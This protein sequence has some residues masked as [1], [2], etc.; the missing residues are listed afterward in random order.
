MG[1][2][3]VA[4]A[5]AAAVIGGCAGG[6]PRQNADGDTIPVRYSS[7]LFYCADSP[8]RKPGF[9]Y[10]TADECGSMRAKLVSLQMELLECRPANAVACFFATDA[11]SG[12]VEKHCHPTV[13]NCITS[14][15]ALSD[16]RDWVDE[17]ECAVFRVKQ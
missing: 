10:D 11:L 8:N 9:C 6:Q 15:M 13:E 4:R 7:H 3:I 16:S 17:T 12:E 14:V 1:N 5:M 2:M